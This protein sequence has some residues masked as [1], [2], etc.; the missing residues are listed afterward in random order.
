MGVLYSSDTVTPNR[1]KSLIANHNVS[2]SKGK[3][4]KKF[5]I[6]CIIKQYKNLYVKIIKDEDK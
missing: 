2:E 1:I 5:N 6:Q 4:E 3:L